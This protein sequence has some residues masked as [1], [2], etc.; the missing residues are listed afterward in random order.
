M[1]VATRACGIS[2]FPFP[3]ESSSVYP[4]FNR[5]CPSKYVM[6]FSVEVSLSFYKTCA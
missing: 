5:F 3:K 6:E 1:T 4:S 2:P